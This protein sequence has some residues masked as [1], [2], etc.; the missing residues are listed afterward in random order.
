MLSWV[1]SALWRG[2]TQGGWTERG[3][4]I[5]ARIQGLGGSEA[6][7]FGEAGLCLRH[8]EEQ[9][10]RTKV[11]RKEKQSTRIMVTFMVDIDRWACQCMPI[12]PAL[13][14]LRHED[15]E[16]KVSLCYLT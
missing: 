8:R 3:E 12:I 2:D 14:R 6:D 4:V 9:N 1:I 13:N 7:V 5:W 16:F 10:N 11:K 15:C